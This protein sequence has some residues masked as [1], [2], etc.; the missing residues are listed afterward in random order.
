MKATRQRVIRASAV[1]T[2]PRPTAG[3]A[4]LL[5]RP[6]VKAKR[7]KKECKD[8][9]AET[10]FHAWHDAQLPAALNMFIDF[11]DWGIPP[12]GTRAVIELVT[13]QI[14]VPKGESARLRMYTSLGSV[15][16]NLDLALTPQGS[17]VNLIDP[18]SP[19]DVFVATHS[20]RA[21][22]DG[23]IQFDINRSTFNTE[24]YALICISGYLA[25]V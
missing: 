21:Y 4:A 2:V 11:S 16:S 22:S 13:A 25:K 17:G 7:P 8:C 9:K 14:V 18:T 20:L 19:V 12:T 24:G 6:A 15:P 3:R 1:V 5:S 23:L 10:A